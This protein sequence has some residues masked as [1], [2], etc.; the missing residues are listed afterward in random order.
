MQKYYLLSSELTIEG[1][2]VILFS[3]P[4][5]AHKKVPDYKEHTIYSAFIDRN[6][7]WHISV[8]VHEPNNIRYVPEAFISEM[9]NGREGEL[10][11]W[12]TSILA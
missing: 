6:G 10:Y 4:Y 8:L 11:E 2:R 5:T 9:V 7:L 12:L 1:G 3:T